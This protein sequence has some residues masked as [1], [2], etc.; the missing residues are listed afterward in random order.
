MERTGATMQH[1]AQ[2]ARHPFLRALALRT[3][4]TIKSDR[5]L[6]FLVDPLKTALRDRDPYGVERIIRL[7]H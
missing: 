3:L 4:S 6:D 7:F 1:D 5:V 2:D